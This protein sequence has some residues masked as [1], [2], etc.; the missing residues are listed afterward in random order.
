MIAI[1]SP[2]L[3]G[4]VSSNGRDSEPKK[5]TPIQ[6]VFTRNPPGAKSLGYHQDNAYA[7]RYPVGDDPNPP[8]IAVVPL[9]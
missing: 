2:Y 6:K 4:I 5:S 8:H 3:R 9:V 7:D 1:A